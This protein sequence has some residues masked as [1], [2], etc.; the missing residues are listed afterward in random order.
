MIASLATRH[1]PGEIE[2]TLDGKPH[3]LC[4]TLGAL[5]ELESAFAVDDLGALVE[6]FSTGRFSAHQSRFN[7][8]SGGRPCSHGQA[9]P[10]CSAAALA[11]RPW[12]HN[13]HSASSGGAVFQSG[14]SLSPD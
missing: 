6:R 2:A 3:V 4:L 13:T 7:S 8:W 11:V 5:A 9:G 14:L 1:S 10:E 12:G